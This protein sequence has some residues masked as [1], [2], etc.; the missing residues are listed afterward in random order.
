[1]Q[2]HVYSVR[3]NV[4]KYT[5][6]HTYVVYSARFPSAITFYCLSVH[7]KEEE[8]TGAP[9]YFLHSNLGEKS[10]TFILSTCIQGR[11]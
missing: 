10:C 6:I 1:M 2:K 9:F 3:K 5:S 7:N 11:F 4:F 8:K